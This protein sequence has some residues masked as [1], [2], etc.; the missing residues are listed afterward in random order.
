MFRKFQFNETYKSL[1][2]LN[3]SFEKAFERG[4]KKARKSKSGEE[5]RKKKGR[6]KEK[7]SLKLIL[8]CTVIWLIDDFLP[9]PFSN[10]NMNRMNISFL[11][12]A[13]TRKSNRIRYL[14]LKKLKFTLK[15]S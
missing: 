1:T 14:K 7:K 10:Q 3:S 6:R 12:F 15:I 13:R 8:I 5:E 11:R 2:N 4:T 9:N